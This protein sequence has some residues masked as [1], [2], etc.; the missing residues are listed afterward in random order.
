MKKILFFCALAVTILLS[1]CGGAS[2]NIN[3]AFDIAKQRGDANEVY[4]LITAS[5]IDY[6]K[7]SMEDL[8]KLGLCSA[9][10]QTSS[11]GHADENTR[12]RN[13]VLGEMSVA[14]MNVTKTWTPEQKDEYM[15]CVKELMKE[16]K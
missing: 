9:Y 6:E 2:G 4:E 3:K 13:K 10:V 7:L 1:A 8:A 11:W 14:L 5:P 16:A 15:E 12:E